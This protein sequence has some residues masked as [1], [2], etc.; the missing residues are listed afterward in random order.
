MKRRAR[1]IGSSEGVVYAEFLVAFV[2]FFL[3][4]LAGVQLASIAEARVV[5]QHA[6]S[7][8]ARAAIVRIDDDPAFYRDGQRKTLSAKGEGRGSERAEQLLEQVAKL[9]A[10]LGVRAEHGQQSGSERLNCVRSAAYLPL[11]S[12]SPSHEQ[13]R[14]WFEGAFGGARHDLERTL[15]EA[16]LLRALTGLALYARVASAVTFPKAA[17]SSALRSFDKP[18]ADDE[19]VRVRVTYLFACNVPLVRMIACRALPSR[20]VTTRDGWRSLFT[21]RAS[22]PDPFQQGVAELGHAEWADMQRML[23]ALSSERF[24]ALRGEAALPNQGAAY[25]YPSELCKS[26]AHAA[27]VDCENAP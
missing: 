1:S 3:L 16:P 10:S 11:A 21:T 13:V 6:A 23:Y 19:T 20:S 17:G 18:W 14:A 7:L 4:F 22:E 8:A 5:V 9:P 2:P 15:G 24:L 26:K 12:V 25:R 27:G